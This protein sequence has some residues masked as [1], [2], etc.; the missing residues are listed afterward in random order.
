MT[1]YRTFFDKDYIG[2]WSL[3]DG[4]D[5]TV[6]ITKVIGGQLTGVGGRKTRKPVIYMQGTEK[7]LALNATNSKTIAGLYGN[8]VEAWVGK[9]VTL[10]KTTTTFGSEQMECVRIRPRVPPPKGQ[11]DDGQLSSDPPPPPPDRLGDEDGSERGPDATVAA[12]PQAST[13]GQDSAAAKP[14]VDHSATVAVILEKI[15][16]IGTGK[17]LDNLVNVTFAEDIDLLRTDAPEVHAKVTDA[18]TAKRKWL[19]R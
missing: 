12:A 10:F 8:H 7:G 14:P 15:E 9:R 18:I 2:A 1:D 3:T 19:A 5:V 11:K 16:K 4:K 6:T 17:G 13:N